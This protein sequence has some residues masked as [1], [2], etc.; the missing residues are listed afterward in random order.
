M[1]GQLSKT[2][3][4]THIILAL[5]VCV[6]ICLAFY[7]FELE[8]SI[9]LGIYNCVLLIHLIC[10]DFQE[11]LKKNHRFNKIFEAVIS[12]SEIA[13]FILG[14]KFL[15]FSAATH[16]SWKG[17]KTEPEKA[18]INERYLVAEIVKFFLNLNFKKITKI[19]FLFI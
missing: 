10:I 8:F 9:Y 15:F 17:I 7:I 11:N 19:I 5:Q 4:L 12:I 16:L 6:A 3:I 2:F 14:L 18:L 13:K 1:S